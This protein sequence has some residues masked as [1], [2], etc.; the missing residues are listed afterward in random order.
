MLVQLVLQH[1]ER[2]GELDEKVAGLDRDKL[3]GA[4][5]YLEA[6]QPDPEAGATHASIENGAHHDRRRDGPDGRARQSPTCS[7]RCTVSET[8]D[9]DSCPSTTP[10][11]S[12]GARQ[13]LERQRKDEAGKAAAETACLRRRRGHVLVSQRLT[14]A[15][16]EAVELKLDDEAA[17]AKAR[18]RRAKL[19]QMNQTVETL[20]AAEEWLQNVAPILPN[21]D[22]ATKRMNTRVLHAGGDSHIPGSR[23][24]VDVC[25]QYE[26]V[27]TQADSAPTVR[28]VPGLEN[29]DVEEKTRGARRFLWISSSP[30]TTASPF[31]LRDYF[32]GERP[33]AV[34]LCLP[35][36]PDALFVGA[37]CG[38]ERGD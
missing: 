32:D 29:V 35:H 15:I 37:R 34:D 38:G 1:D 23:A 13:R 27:L 10:L 21:V 18:S 17:R 16:A 7:R 6:G 2:P 22:A 5:D 12:L 19:R 36:V 30:I 33:V 4:A 9:V 14:R 25:A 11:A 8:T 26:Q 24:S 31:A 3:S 28:E 20:G